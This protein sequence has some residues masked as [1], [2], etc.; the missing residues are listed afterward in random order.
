MQV[1]IWAYMID[2]FDIP[3]NEW[4]TKLKGL[5]VFYQ[6]PHM[7]S[8]EYGII[9]GV[10][11]CP[12]YLHVLFIGDTTAKAVCLRDLHWPPD[13]CKQD[14]VNPEHQLYSQT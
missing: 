1:R 4:E 9:V 3:S 10:Q 12:H 11:S 6:Q 7:K 5:H 14:R 8:P 13:Y 2:P